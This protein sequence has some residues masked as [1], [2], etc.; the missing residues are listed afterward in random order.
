MLLAS[1]MASPGRNHR[2]FMKLNR[3]PTC[4]STDVSVS[5]CNSCN[6]STLYMKT[7]SKRLASGISY[8]EVRIAEQL[9]KAASDSLPIFGVSNLVCSRRGLCGF[10][11]FL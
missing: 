10:R 11:I 3:L 8:I 6:T 5:P 4:S 1:G 7:E 2:K 9:H